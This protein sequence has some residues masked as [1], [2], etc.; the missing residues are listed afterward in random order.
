MK[1]KTN[2][3]FICFF[4]RSTLLFQ[5]FLKNSDNKVIRPKASIG[6]QDT[7]DSLN[8]ILKVPEVSR[9]SSQ[10]F[11]FNRYM[12]SNGVK[13]SAVGINFSEKLQTAVYITYL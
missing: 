13:N 8:L 5:K 10:V 6:S 2:N 11:N 12:L 3:Y 4:K 7:Q 1:N 9:F